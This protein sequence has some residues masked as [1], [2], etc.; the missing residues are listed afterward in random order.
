MS[1]LLRWV[2]LVCLAMWVVW[3]PEARGFEEYVRAETV[4][5]APTTTVL[6]VP[7]S[8][9]LPTSYALPTHVPATIYSNSFVPTTF[10][11][12]PTV[13]VVPTYQTII[14][15]GQSRIVEGPFSTTTRYDDLSPTT[16]CTPVM[17]EWPAA[18]VRELQRETTGFA[19]QKT[20]VTPVPDR[21]DLTPPAD[22]KTALSSAV[23]PHEAAFRVPLPRSG[24]ADGEVVSGTTGQAMS[25]LRIIASQRL[26][27]RV[28]T[29]REAQTDALGRFGIK[30]PAGDWAIKGVRSD[31][32]IFSVKN[33]AVGSGSITSD[34]TLTLDPVRPGMPTLDLSPTSDTGPLGDHRTSA[35]RVLLIGRADPN[36]TI[37]L[38][39]SGAQTKADD[40]GLL[41]FPG[42]ALVPGENVV[43]AR[44]VSTAGQA[45]DTPLTITR[46][47][48]PSPVDPVLAW[49][50]MTLEAIRGDAVTPPVA[51]RDLAIVSVAIFDTVSA[52]RGTSG[53]YVQETAP[54]PASPEAA[55]AAA[56]H[57]AL[58]HLY[59]KR[60][61][62]FDA[63]LA[64]SLAAVP[65]GPGKDQGVAL[66]RTVADAIL[67]LRADDG[68]GDQK[69][70]SPGSGPGAWRPTPPRYDPPLMPEWATVRPFVLASPR[71]FRP[72]GPPSLGSRAWADAYNEVKAIGR[73]DSASRTAE[74]TEIAG[75][76]A[77]GTGTYTPPG[78][79]NQIAAQLAEEKG[80][81]LAANARLFAALNLA[82]ADA[83]IACWDAKYVYRFW[84]PVTAIRAAATDGNPDTEPD[85]SWAPLLTTPSFPEYVSGHSTFSGA[86]EV[87]LSSVFGPDVAF[88]T[89]SP[90]HPGVT[91]SYTS[92]HA[93][94]EEA[95]LS[96][97]YGGI[98]F[99]FSNQDGLTTG[100]AVARYVLD[101]L[102]VTT[103]AR[104]P[105]AVNNPP[106]P[107][108]SPVG[109]H[110]Q[111]S[112]GGEIFWPE[113]LANL[114][115][116]PPAWPVLL[117]K[118]HGMQR[119]FDRRFR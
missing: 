45:I 94:A 19:P 24:I 43:T 62:T 36:I 68:W 95:A 114:R 100:H 33:I 11:L 3:A 74:Q 37:I 78:H 72:P 92:F 23:R 29:D 4:S 34:V 42:V 47:G 118:F 55:T 65:D 73:T 30:L 70:D 102:D 60:A 57:R 13:R 93:A 81:S 39:P 52:I 99:Q 83:A 115:F 88:R 63:A 1:F 54:A 6:A 16:C 91:R 112:P 58:V 15:P 46:V 9:A 48:K 66:G 77:D 28:F 96:R 17:R 5:V 69:G 105:R 53:Y 8:S 113:D 107:R 67:A 12:S 40:A 110:C 101:S 111:Y 49:V 2:Q 27:P 97:L 22:P 18:T 119:R 89:S 109:P 82:L 75:I 51:T 25:D 86:A 80:N 87:V 98:H 79:W 85:P 26:R 21:G 20:E 84:R 104:P 50:R 59:P 41:Q 61:A 14:S 64:D 10:Y 106:A 116:A 90:G 76:W 7:T 103:T 117:V 35:A 32:K 56:A 71:Q 31:G 38:L 108:P 44:V